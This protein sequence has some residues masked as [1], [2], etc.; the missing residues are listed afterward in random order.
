MYHFWGMLNI[1]SGFVVL[2]QEKDQLNWQMN[3]LRLF[4]HRIRMAKRV[5]I[6]IKSGN[7]LIDLTLIE[8]RLENLKHSLHY[9]VSILI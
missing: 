5:E 6:K 7:M 2:F 8:L 4:L 3:Q 9:F 1:Y